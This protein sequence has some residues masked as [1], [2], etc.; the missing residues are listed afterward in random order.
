MSY[1]GDIRLGRAIRLARMIRGLSQQ[2][3]ATAAD[4]PD[5]SVLG[6][7][8]NAH[9]AVPHSRWEKL[10]TV[11]GIEFAD[12]TLTRYGTDRL[13]TAG[14][15]AQVFLWAGNSKIDLLSA[16]ATTSPQLPLPGA[17]AQP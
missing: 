2:E 17:T 13:V 6:Q 9:R 4:F 3:L 7:W 1:T 5:R 10:V 12:L 16:G 8:E 15:L 14:P 11:L